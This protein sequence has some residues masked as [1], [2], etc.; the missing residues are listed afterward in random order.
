MIIDAHLDLAYNATRGRN[1]LLPAAQQVSQDKTIPTV[2]LPDLLRGDVK[3][4]CATLFA[5]PNH[6][7]HAGY[8]NPQEA[9]N[10]ASVQMSWYEQQE[11]AGRLRLIRS[12]KDLPIPDAASGPK[13]GVT[14][15]TS[16]AIATI[17]LMEGGDSMRDVADAEK[18]FAR[19]VRIVGM[20]WKRTH[21]CGG[22][23]ESGPLTPLGI[24]MIREFDRLKIIHDASHLAEES[25]WQLSELS[26]GP[27]MASHSNCR[28][29]VPTD[30]QLSDDMIKSIIARKGVIGINFFDRFLVPPAE[31][32]SRRASLDDVV[33]H[34][35]HICNLA[36]NANHVAIG[37]DMDGGLGKEQIPQEITA[38]SDLY[39]LKDALRASGFT[40]VAIE[41]IMWRNWLEYFGKNLAG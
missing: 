9:Y 25:F 15:E 2:G 7:G 23:G 22:T 21:L 1:V 34:I 18:W 4:I 41:Q 8:R 36:G 3:L 16:Q 39:L 6:D 13:A 26:D 35:Q 24:E 10:D 11:K 31:Y 17:V 29:I 20:A 32:K 38:S 19:G 12:A 14:D 40:T 28:S 33:A 5:E 30:R 27:I 37:T